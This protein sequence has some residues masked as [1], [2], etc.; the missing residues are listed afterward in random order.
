MLGNAVMLR[1]QS[2][3]KPTARPRASLFASRSG[4]QSPASRTPAPGGWGAIPG[5]GSALP[6][7]KR[8]H[9]GN[10]SVLGGRD[11]EG[12]H[13]V[14]R[15]GNRHGTLR[16]WAPVVSVV[17][18]FLNA[19]ALLPAPALAASGSE[20]VAAHARLSAGQLEGTTLA[21]GSG[22]N[23]PQG[24]PAVRVLQRRLV[25]AGDSPGPIDGLYG[26]LTR[27]AVMRFQASRGLAVDG[28]VGPQ[29]WTLTRSIVLSPGL[30]GHDPADLVQTLQRRL[31]AAGF[32]PGPIDGQFG[33]VTEQ[34]VRRFQIAHGLPADGIIGGR[35]R[36]LLGASALVVHRVSRHPM[37]RTP[38]ATYGAPA[39]HQSP[40]VH[41][42]PAAHGTPVARGTPA[43]N[44][45]PAAHQAPAVRATPT[46]HP[47]GT[48][49]WLFGVLAIIGVALVA[50]VLI[51]RRPAGSSLAEAIRESKRYVSAQPSAVPTMDCKPQLPP[52]LVIAAV[53]D[54]GPPLPAA[55]QRQP[56]ASSPAPVPAGRPSADNGLG[57]NG[58]HAA[59]G[60]GDRRDFDA[61][62]A[63]A[64]VAD[65]RH[66]PADDVS[67]GQRLEKH[68]KVSE[69]EAAYRRAGAAGEAGEAGAAFQLA[70]LLERCGSREK[71]EAAYRRADQRGH[72]AAAANL[73]VMLEE[74]GAIAEAEAAYRRADQ[75]DV[76]EA[77][78]N[79]G[80]LLEER[81]ALAEAAQAYRRAD[82]RGHGA[83]AA[84]L[85]VMLEERGAI[86]GAEAAYRRAD[87]RD[88]AEAAFNL[89]ALLEER[90]ALAEAAQAYRRANQR[91][92]G[93]IAEMARAALTELA[94]RQPVGS[95]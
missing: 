92:D 67:L 19:S 82:R 40:A 29:T 32:A 79:L 88:V 35:T 78:F 16:F 57:N 95:A 68:G 12:H 4:V 38:R 69:A 50:V 36:A 23:S 61:P 27:S 94:A 83:A 31:A 66:D 7:E 48:P 90:G 54:V 18:L 73:G 39:A 60:N 77:A 47:A 33:L 41:S 34:A 55:A 74:R 76:A 44:N 46:S 17:A 30:R 93:E 25:L 51:R 10:G 65:E 64:R 85:G 89:G 3:P 52:A 53:E 87:Q 8:S 86:A 75:R 5:A 24:S 26:P 15:G 28:I 14:R 63:V 1:G 13:V 58:H 22:Y 70:V 91:G 20:R 84:N 42:R 49:Q 6:A 43:T 2:G 81:G 45:S 11:A 21:L 56:P 59:N 62:A 9:R 37:L 80:T 72:G 71:A